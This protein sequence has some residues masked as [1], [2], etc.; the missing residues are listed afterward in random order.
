LLGLLPGLLVGLFPGGVLGLLP[1]LLVGLFPGVVLGL[2]LG[3]P[4]LPVGVL[5]GVGIDA[6]SGVEDGEPVGAT[7]VAGLAPA[8]NRLPGRSDAIKANALYA[9]GQ[10]EKLQCPDA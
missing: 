9:V 3:L 1:G 2:L 6:S 7:V 5:P 4:G 8:V 10:P